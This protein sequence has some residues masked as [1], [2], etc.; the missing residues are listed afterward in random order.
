MKDEYMK[1]EQQIA[2]KVLNY[3]AFKVAKSNNW[4]I[5]DYKWRIGINRINSEYARYIVYALNRNLNR[6]GSMNFEALYVN[7]MDLL[8]S[9]LSSDPISMLSDIMSYN[10]FGDITVGYL[11][12]TLVLSKN[13][14]IENIIDEMEIS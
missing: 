7:N 4:N 14:S 2:K 6:V 8:A 3:L 10:K 13:T 12:N 9:K 5:K 1:N 11:N